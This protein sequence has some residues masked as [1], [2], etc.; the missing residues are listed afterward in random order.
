MGLLKIETPLDNGQRD[1][2]KIEQKG[3]LE[4]EYDCSEEGFSLSRLIL[5]MV[6]VYDNTVAHRRALLAGDRA[7]I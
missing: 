5:A 6:S 3:I 1:E 2:R 4:H 7:E